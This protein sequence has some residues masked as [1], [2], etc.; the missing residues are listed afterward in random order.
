M[1]RG[2]GSVQRRLLSAIAAI[3]G[4]AEGSADPPRTW[5]D[6]EGQLWIGLREPLGR[7]RIGEANSSRIVASLERRELLVAGRIW[8]P[9]AGRTWGAMLTSAGRAAL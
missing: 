6:A 8:T 1:S 3:E 4:E 2:L 7:A 9:R 5:R